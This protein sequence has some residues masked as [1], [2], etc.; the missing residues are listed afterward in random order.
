MAEND[1]PSLPPSL[2]D[3]YR[4]YKDL[5]SSFTTWLASTGERCGFR[6]STC[7]Q[8]SNHPPEPSAQKANSRLK[9]K[10][11]KLAR[12]ADKTAQITKA[13]TKTLLL[14]DFIPIAKHIAS[15]TK[16]PQYTPSSVLTKLQRAID[17]RR[18]CASWFNTRVHT[19]ASLMSNESHEHFIEVLSTVLD[20]LKP[21]CNQSTYLAKGSVDKTVIIIT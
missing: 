9:G 1:L 10:A 16:P 8:A 3:S 18:R 7:K 12:D 13:L 14:K 2:V 20:I 6:L 5:T 19:T 4:H 17:L 11:R 15:S 21:S